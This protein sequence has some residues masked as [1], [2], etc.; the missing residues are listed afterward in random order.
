MLVP[1]LPSGIWPDISDAAISAVFAEAARLCLTNQPV[2]PRRAAV[3]A[4]FELQLN[5]SAAD[6]RALTLGTMAAVNVASNRPD[7][8]VAVPAIVDNVKSDNVATSSPPVVNLD[9][10]CVI[11]DDMEDVWP[12]IDPNGHGGG[13][14]DLFDSRDLN[15]NEA[16]AVSMG[17]QPEQPTQPVVDK[18]ME[19]QQQTSSLEPFAAPKVSSVPADQRGKKRRGSRAGHERRRLRAALWRQRRNNTATYPPPTWTTPLQRVE[20]R[21]QQQRWMAEA[22]RFPPP[23]GLQYLPPVPTPPFPRGIFAYNCR[24]Q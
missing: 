15:D 10:S 21:L 12:A 22:L 14:S 6:A 9:L 2:E 17:Q 23:M 16:P 13:W 8:V 4:H 19:Q 7:A 5:A 1:V 3:A 20:A 11:D 24:F 18:A